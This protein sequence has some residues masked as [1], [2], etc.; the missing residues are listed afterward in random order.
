MSYLHKGDNFSRLHKGDNFSHL[1]KGDYLGR[2]HRQ[3]LVTE[4]RFLLGEDV[5][6]VNVHLQLLP[7]SRSGIHAEPEI[8]RLE[9]SKN[10]KYADW[11][12][13]RI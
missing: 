8:C 3:G 2:L 11:R 10:L 4:A 5:L 1:H 13:H 7:L 12:G 9:G 6:D